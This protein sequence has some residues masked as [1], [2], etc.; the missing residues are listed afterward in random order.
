[1]NAQRSSLTV[2]GW[3]LRN[4]TKQKQRESGGLWMVRGREGG[5]R[6]RGV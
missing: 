3:A 2:R 4:E 6:G 1:M 5:G